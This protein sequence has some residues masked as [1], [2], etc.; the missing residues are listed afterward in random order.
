M[1]KRAPV[2]TVIT[3]LVVICAFWAAPVQATQEDKSGLF[4]VESACGNP[5]QLGRAR[6]VGHAMMEQFL[7]ASMP[8]N[9]PVLNEFVNRVGQNLARA[10]G[11]R[12]V[13]EFRVVYSP[14]VNAR[15]FPGGYVV[16]NTGVISLAE[17]EAELAAVL[18]HEIAHINSCHT[19][20]HSR[21]TTALS[22]ASVLTLT[23]VPGPVGAALGYSSM[24]VTPLAASYANRST[25]RVADRL[26]V[27]YL[28]L[29]GYD[30][31]AEA[32]LLQRLT[33][34][35]Q[36]RQV[37]EGGVL[38]THPPPGTR[39]REAL[40]YAEH[41]QCPARVLTNTSE[42]AELRQT[43]LQYDETYAA[44]T[45]ATLPGRPPTPPCLTRRPEREGF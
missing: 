8:W 44:A 2:G 37:K 41:T 39:S 28:A 11:G 23:L 27:H 34:A 3:V 43:V 15:S 24:A 31:T 25:E 17:D 4:P 6:I 13:F 29:A 26:A 19:Q 22:A 5:S 36:E 38:A 45:G 14:E 16:V 40:H 9:D 33:E 35:D 32:R 30:P 7:A 18:A 21:L 10:S 12:Q 1:R 20:R 42:Y